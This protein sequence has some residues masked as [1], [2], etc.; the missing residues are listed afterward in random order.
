[1]SL[2]NHDPAHPAPPKSEDARFRLG[3]T[4][5]RSISE[6][7]R[8]SSRKDLAAYT[9]LDALAFDERPSFVVNSSNEPLQHVP[10][11]LVYCNPALAAN[12]ELLAKLKEK[13][14][15]SVM[16]TDIHSG[17]RSWLYDTGDQQATAGS[18]GTCTEIFTTRCF[19]A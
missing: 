14:D 15:P 2:Q 16:F 13:D 17:F 4:S 3:A 18:R 8:V 19:L 7:K 5:I 10:L 1:M 11:D 6:L 9:L 12:G